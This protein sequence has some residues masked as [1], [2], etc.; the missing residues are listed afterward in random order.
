MTAWGLMLA[1]VA[2]AEV[3]DD[4]GVWSAV[5]VQPNLHPARDTGPELWFDL[6]GRA[7]L[8]GGMAG[9]VRP[10]VGWVV[11]PGVG[12]W[13]GYAWIGTAT[14]SATLRHEHRA[15]QQLTLGKAWGPVSVGGRLRQEQRVRGVGEPVGHRVRLLGRVAVSLGG[16]WTVVGS[17][18]LFLGYHRTDWQ[19]AGFD[20]NRAFVGFGLVAKEQGFRVEAGYQNVFLNR[21]PDDTAL[22]TAAVNLF[23]APRA[24]ARK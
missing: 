17:D 9:I 8:N 16:P 22:H 24:K 4:A 7:N 21:A 2:Q 11:A 1:L 3:V 19:P 13:V 10:G 15:W 14:V 23:V 6:H 5:F 20:Q 18:E 12:V